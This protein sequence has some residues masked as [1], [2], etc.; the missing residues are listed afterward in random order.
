MNMQHDK[1]NKVRSLLAFAGG[2]MQTLDSTFI[3]DNYTGKNW[4]RMGEIEHS[5][6]II[7]RQF[8]PQQQYQNPTSFQGQAHYAQP[9]QYQQP[10]VEQ[11][12]NYQ[13]MNRNT[14]IS[15]EDRI[16]RFLGKTT[17]TNKNNNSQSLDKVIQSAIAPME[18]RLEDMSVLLGLVVQRLEQL[19]NIVDETPHYEYASQF[20]EGQVQQNSFQVEEEMPVENE[21]FDPGVSMSLTDDEDEAPEVIT[22][23]KKRKKK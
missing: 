18:E 9:V 20:Q 7:T 6:N 2:G 5:D 13:I 17:T 16:N 22:T 14:S 12:D 3:T 15:R 11:V 21:V 4:N 19:I 8:I 1:L 23:T 10:P